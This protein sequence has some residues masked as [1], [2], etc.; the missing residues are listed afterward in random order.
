MDD[1]TVLAVGEAQD[2]DVTHV[3]KITLNP[4]DASLKG[5]FAVHTEQGTHPGGV[6]FELTGQ[7]VTE[8]VGG[9]E[10]ITDE[11]RVKINLTEG[12]MLFYFTTFVNK[13]RRALNNRQDRIRA[14]E[15][16]EDI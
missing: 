13:H 7:N 9:A 15:I 16:W 2:L 5:F 4:V 3:G 11:D 10:D 14:R 8:C 6:H 1:I 12:R